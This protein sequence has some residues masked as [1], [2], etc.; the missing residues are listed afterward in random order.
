MPESF[1]SFSVKS[2]QGDPVNLENYKGKVVL[3]VNVASACG[4]TPQY[5]GLEE[6]YRKFK[7]KGFVILGFPCNQFGGQESASDAD[8]QTF[9]KMTY[10]VSF[11]VMGKID[12]NGTKADPLYKF[13]KEQAPGI[14]GTEGV[15]WN[16]T[17][18]LVNKN[19]EIVK[20]YPPQVVPTDI[21]EDV[22]PLL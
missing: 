5:K 2:A 11:P 13:M 4:F 6:L 16:F 18:F 21:A 7:D 22:E 20:R 9:C 10:D 8:I 14:L 12:V 1:H 3:V 19:G 15:K 17:K